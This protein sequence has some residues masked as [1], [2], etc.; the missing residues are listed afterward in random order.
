MFSPAGFPLLPSRRR[1]RA[2]RHAVNALPIS[3]RRAMLAA[4]EADEIIAGAYIDRGGRVCPM[5]AAHRRGARTEARSFARAWDAFA[6]VRRPRPASAR[7]R[8]ILIALLQESLDDGLPAEIIPARARGRANES[9]RLD[10]P[11]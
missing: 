9:P 4:V 10:V 3:T 6:H 11:A 7:E 2:L 5:L 1:A 8:E